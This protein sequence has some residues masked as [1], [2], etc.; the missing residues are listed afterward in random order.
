M[1]WWIGVVGIALSATASVA[2]AGNNDTV[3]MGD[4]AALAGAAVVAAGDDSGSVAY[5]PAGLLGIDRNS[6]SLSASFFRVQA[7]QV[8][9]YLVT[10]TPGGPTQAAASRGSFDTVPP[11]VIFGRRLRPNLAGALSLTVP[12]SISADT[13]KRTN[14]AVSGIQLNESLRVVTSTSVY[15]FGA[16]VAWAPAPN[17]RIGGT[18][19]AG[20]FRTSSGQEFE[21]SLVDAAGG[22]TYVNSV[23]VQRGFVGALGGIAGVQWSITPRIAAGLTVETPF[24]GLFGSVTDEQTKFFSRTEPGQTPVVADTR[25]LQ[26]P[27]GR[28]E[29]FGTFVARLGV[30]Y[31]PHWGWVSL[32]VDYRP[33]PIDS[34]PWQDKTVTNGRGGAVVDLSPTIRVGAGGFTDFAPRRSSAD[35]GFDFVGGTAGVI[36]KRKLALRDA[37]QPLLLGTTFALRYAYGWGRASGLSSDISSTDPDQFAVLA[38]APGSIH[39]VSFYIGSGVNF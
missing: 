4:L 23:V 17:V 12:E 22:R 16:T 25:N 26:S 3:P 32:Q 5:N 10:Q 38:P 11:A 7:T 9:G 13:D 27:S 18:F 2:W 36:W 31:T 15:R 21:L 6:V 33:Q 24:L 39:E 1:R 19:N 34:L 37:P 14:P 29:R 20:V 28:G 30:A 8:P 35:V